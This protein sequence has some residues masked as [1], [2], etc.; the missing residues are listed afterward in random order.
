[1]NTKLTFIAFKIIFASMVILGVI[2]SCGGDPY[3]SNN[4]DPGDNNSTTT[5][6]G[7]GVFP[8][9]FILEDQTYDTIYLKKIDNQTT[10]STRILPIKTL[11]TEDPKLQLKIKNIRGE[12][13]NSI[14]PKIVQNYVQF[15]FTPNS[16]TQSGLSLVVTGEHNKTTLPLETVETNW[17]PFLSFELR[18]QSGKIVSLKQT[19]GN[20]GVAIPEEQIIALAQNSSTQGNFS[21]VDTSG[22]FNIGF[23]GGTVPSNPDLY[24]LNTNDDVFKTELV[25]NQQGHHLYVLPNKLGESATITLVSVEDETEA[26][27]IKV[28]TTQI[29]K[30]NIEF[31]YLLASNTN[32]GNLTL[33][34]YNTPQ[35]VT[36]ALQEI[37]PNNFFQETTTQT[38]TQ[39][40]T[41][42]ITTFTL[43]PTYAHDTFPT[44]TETTIIAT[45]YQ[46][47]GTTPLTDIHGNTITATTTVTLVGLNINNANINSVPTETCGFDAY[48]ITIVEGYLPTFNTKGIIESVTDIKLHEELNATKQYQATVK[49][50]DLDID[51]K[52]TD[53]DDNIVAAGALICL[54]E[55]AGSETI[56]HGGNAVD[57]V[58]PTSIIGTLNVAG[59][60]FTI[61]PVDVTPTVQYAIDT[62]I[63]VATG[64]TTNM[65]ISQG[66]QLT[67]GTVV[68]YDSDKQKY[69][70]A[71]YL[72][73]LEFDKIS[74]PNSIFQ[75]PPHLTDFKPAIF[76]GSV[77]LTIKEDALVGQTATFEIYLQ[78]KKRA[79]QSG[80]GFWSDVTDIDFVDTPTV[81]TVTV[82]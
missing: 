38:T 60:E 57:P 69:D 20:G 76:N 66:A 11:G 73:A 40:F 29:L 48:P 21:Q 1:M 9:S 25:K 18:N 42:N 26:A 77:E 44:G 39:T 72:I 4:D 68:I 3:T 33:Q 23:F 46:K 28:A 65:E 59:T 64:K 2:I 82:K 12:I 27:V 47:D 30:P 35:D 81:V 62:N 63:A 13:D 79:F 15:S 55:I 51:G 45:L 61:D 70:P 7:Y 50:V 80:H 16:E 58:T 19:R 54:Q 67:E 43:T 52:V 22:K 32:P 37:G 75:T 34:T 36:V 17:K 8:A 14:T 24:I 31:I 41:N 5:L 10:I 71:K 78:R 56:L 49:R 74:D 6:S 53:A